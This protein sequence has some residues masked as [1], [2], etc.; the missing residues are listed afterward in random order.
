VQFTDPDLTIDYDVDRNAATASRKKLLAEAAAQGYLVGGA[1]ISFPG[2]GHVSADRG[3]IT[4]SHFP[5]AQLSLARTG[6]PAATCNGLV[7]CNRRGLHA[8]AGARFASGP[9]WAIGRY[10]LHQKDAEPGIA[11]EQRAL[12]PFQDFDVV[13]VVEFE[14]RCIDAADVNVIDISRNGRFIAYRIGRRPDATDERGLR[15][16]LPGCTTVPAPRATA[17]PCQ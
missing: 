12:R 1:H 3:G 2:L 7:R 15:R 14:E 4:G 13:D 16:S 9:R 8:G 5:T 10:G 6:E 17:R 11:A